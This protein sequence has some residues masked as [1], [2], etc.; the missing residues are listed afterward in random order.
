MVDRFTF[1]W[2]GGI[3]AISLLV[4]AFFPSFAKYA[5]SASLVFTLAL[6]GYQAQG[7]YLGFRGFDN[8]ID[9]GSKETKALLS[10]GEMQ[11]LRIVANSNFDGRLASFWLDGDFALSLVPTGTDA[12]EF[13]EGGAVL[14]VGSFAGLEEKPTFEMDGIA[15]FGSKP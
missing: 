3:I 7:Q 6:T 1:E 13:I 14:L 9:Q 11:E 8:S 10:H 15:L 5:V 2:T 4:L 12:S